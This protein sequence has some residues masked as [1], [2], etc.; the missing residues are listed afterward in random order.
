MYRRGRDCLRCHQFTEADVSLFVML[1]HLLSWPKRA[2]G[3]F[4]MVE[5]LKLRKALLT[6]C[7]L[8]RSWRDPDACG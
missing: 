7:R 3:A 6:R 5:L 1:V 2:P 8:D 4:T